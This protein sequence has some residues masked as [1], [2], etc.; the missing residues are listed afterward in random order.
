MPSTTE[1]VLAPYGFL[2]PIVPAK[3]RPAVAA[4]RCADSRAR[5]EKTS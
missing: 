3:Y 4:F 1:P 2:V 5:L